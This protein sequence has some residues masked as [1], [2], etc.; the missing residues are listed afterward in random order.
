M[1]LTTSS[2]L[3]LFSSDYLKKEKSHY[4][5]LNCGL[6]YCSSYPPPFSATLL[7]HDSISLNHPSHRL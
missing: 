7:R 6:S 1:T 5:S 4:R 3:E 2:L